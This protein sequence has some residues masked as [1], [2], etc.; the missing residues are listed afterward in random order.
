MSANFR[1]IECLLNNL[2]YKFDVIT[3]SE[4]W[5]D[6]HTNILSF[7]LDN[8]VLYHIDRENKRGGGVAIYVSN[9]L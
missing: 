2:K 6:K 9:T 7:S 3:V 1:K 8:Y 5:F 4:T